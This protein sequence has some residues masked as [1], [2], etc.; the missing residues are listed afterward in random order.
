MLISVYSSGPC[1]T[2]EK[3]RY[4]SEDEAYVAAD[5]IF[6]ASTRTLDPYL[7]ACGLWHLATPLTMRGQGAITKPPGNGTRAKSRTHVKPPARGKWTR[8]PRQAD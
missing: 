6:D 3:Q 5:Y 7:C 1:P 8:R 4:A 2:P